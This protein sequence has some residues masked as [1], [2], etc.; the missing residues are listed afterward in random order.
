MFFNKRSTTKGINIFWLLLIL[1]VNWHAS[2]MPGLAVGTKILTPSGLVAIEDLSVGDRVIGYDPTTHEYLSV[3][4]KDISSYALFDF[5]II[6]TDKG[7]ITTSQDQLFYDVVQE[8][9]IPAMAINKDSVF[10][11]YDN[12]RCTCIG[13]VKGSAWTT[14]YDL[15][16]NEPH[17]FFS[18]EAQIVTHNFVPAA[19]ALYPL[20][21]WI[22]GNVIVIACG[23]LGQPYKY[24]TDLEQAKK[25]VIQESIAH[26]NRY[27]ELINDGSAYQNFQTNFVFNPNPV[28]VM[29]IQTNPVPYYNM[30]KNPFLYGPIC[31]TAEIQSD[32][33]IEVVLYVYGFCY[34]D[35][36]N[37]V[38]T[39]TE[40]GR[41]IVRRDHE[42]VKFF[43]DIEDKKQLNELRNFVRTWPS[44]MISRL[45]TF[46]T[47][48]EKKSELFCLYNGITKK[49]IYERAFDVY[50][51][52]HM[53]EKNIS[54]SLAVQAIKYGIC[55]STCSWRHF[56]FAD[57]RYNVA[58][59][60]NLISGNIIDVGY[61]GDT[62][63]YLKLE[64]KNPDEAI[65]IEDYE[66][67][68][69]EDVSE[70]TDEK[71]ESGAKT[72]EDILEDAKPKKDGTFTEQYS[73]PGGVE[74]ANQD[75]DDLEPADVRDLGDGKGWEYY[76]MEGQ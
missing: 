39:W 40:L 52:Y 66:D 36:Q 60:I 65:E 54:P 49:I 28:M 37:R 24:F 6:E 38:F 8:K 21:E 13:V 76:L 56:I 3:P 33:D 29:G 48:V 18:S 53:V 43:M 75:F 31:A 27:S 34:E 30:I 2:I 12:E 50:A 25:Q 5:L 11:T 58:I 23:Y 72:V 35:G 62:F 67:G 7:I 14:F 9:F 45:F 63:A 61:Y 69:N 4:I 64:E 1:I 17:I 10:I 51:L 57:Q 70:E 16:L 32:G 41:Q 19:A 22:L 26:A 74:G 46:D 71:E 47:P 59:L 42:L 20:T 15:T 55:A 73:K 44:S 68:E